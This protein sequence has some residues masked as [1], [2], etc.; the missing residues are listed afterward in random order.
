MHGLRGVMARFSRALANAGIDMLQ[1]VDSHATIS[2]LVAADRA[3]DAVRELH[4]EFI[5]LE[6][7]DEPGN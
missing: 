3:E 7:G 4:A 6:E 1:T 2:A 5:E